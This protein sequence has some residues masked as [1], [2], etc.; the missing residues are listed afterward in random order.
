MNCKLLLSEPFLGDLNFTRSV[1][2]IVEENAEGTLGLVVNK[3]TE[4]LLGDA[5]VQLAAFE[6]CL[7]IGGPV[8]QNTLHFIHRF[9]DRI[10]G[11]LEIVDNLYWGGDQQILI[12]KLH[13]R[14]IA[15][16]EIRF[17]LGYTGWTNQQ[18]KEEMEQNLWI[19]ASI[20]S[21]FI[22]ENNAEDLWRTILINMGGRFKDLA[23][24]PLDPRWN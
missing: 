14:E 24:Y 15:T 20:N 7:Y 17:F 11:D 2:L 21:D 13:S 12:Q 22:F 10:S 19:E 18:L 1:V 6:D 5:V 9:K 23:N 8:S 3:P 16:D 4:L